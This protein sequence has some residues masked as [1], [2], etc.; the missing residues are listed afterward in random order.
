MCEGSLELTHT[1]TSFRLYLI[2]DPGLLQD[3]CALGCCIDRQVVVELSESLACETQ[4]GIG[5]GKA[6]VSYVILI[7]G[8][9]QSLIIVVVHL[10]SCLQEQV[11]LENK[12]PVFRLKGKTSVVRDT[13]H[14][15]LHIYAWRLLRIC[16][17][18]SEE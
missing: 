13:Q 3:V 17:V 1:E 4:Y 15:I 6:R 9:V 7:I 14:A 18:K 5:N 10:S 12:L 11:G 8:L 16:K 2:V